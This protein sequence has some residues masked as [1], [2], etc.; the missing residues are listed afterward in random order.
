MALSISIGHELSK[1]VQGHAES[2]LALPFTRPEPIVAHRMLRGL[3]PLMLMIYRRRDAREIPEV[4]SG[5]PQP[6]HLIACASNLRNR[7]RTS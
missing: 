1:A 4:P 3:A 5:H 7:W 6:E 2:E